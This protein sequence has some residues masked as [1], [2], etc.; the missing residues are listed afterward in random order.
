MGPVQKAG[1]SR[2]IV[3]LLRERGE[4]LY[5]I[6]RESSSVLLIRIGHLH[7]FQIK[8]DK[9]PLLFGKLYGGL[10]RLH[11]IVLYKRGI[12]HLVLNEM[13]EVKLYDRHDQTDHKSCQGPDQGALHEQAPRTGSTARVQDHQKDTEHDQ[14]R[15][16]KAP[17]GILLQHA[18]ACSLQ[19]SAQMIEYL[20]HLKTGP[21]RKSPDLAERKDS[22]KRDKKQGDRCSCL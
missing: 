6:L 4:L 20:I 1:G 14:S 17:R 9:V 10:D 15:G 12:I 22:R 13:N 8:I 11:V 2:E 18:A 5:H 7:G 21:C 16:Q 19:G 3:A